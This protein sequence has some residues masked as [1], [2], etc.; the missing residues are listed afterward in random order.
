MRNREHPISLSLV[1]KGSR[2][3][4]AYLTAKELNTN[5]FYICSNDVAAKQMYNHYPFSNRVFLPSQ[6]TE[7]GIIETKSNAVLSER[8]RMLADL[9]KGNNVV[10]LS[11]NSFLYK[12]CPHGNFYNSAFSIR[13]GDFSEPSDIVKKLVS[14]GYE[15]TQLIDSVGQVSGRGEIVEVYP[16]NYNNPIRI[17][18]FDDEIE[19]IKFFDEETQR[20]FGDVIGDCVILPAHEFVFTDT[21][22]INIKNVLLSCVDSKRSSIG[23]RFSF[24]LDEYSY[25]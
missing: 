12:M 7:V 10:F 16:P 23:E 6:Q 1:A 14:L 11:I 2:G 9:K 15:R 24:E 3:Y 18:F 19:S 13:I 25:F 17:T 8:M 21:E 5:V 20:S 22:K 4:L